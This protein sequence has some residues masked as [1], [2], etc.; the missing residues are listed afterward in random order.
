MNIGVDATT[1]RLKVGQYD[2]NGN[3]LNTA[4]GAF[5]YDGVNR[6]VQAND[7]FYAYDA[8]NRRVYHYDF[9]NNKT[10]TIYFYGA[11]KE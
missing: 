2:A 6:I 10:E 1:N 11:Y 5:V 9:Y 4:T 7:D 3:Q 8:E